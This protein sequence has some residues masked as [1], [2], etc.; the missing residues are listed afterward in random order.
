MLE[1]AIERARLRGA[2]QARLQARRL[3]EAA[4]DAAPA[5]VAVEDSEEGFALAGR[6]LRRRLALEPALRWLMERMR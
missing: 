4:A 1:K 5:G 2:E 6:G 3:A